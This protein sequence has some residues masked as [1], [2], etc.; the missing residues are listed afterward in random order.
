MTASPLIS[1]SAHKLSGGGDD[2]PFGLSTMS[3]DNSVGKALRWRSGGRFPVIFC[4]VAYFLGKQTKLLKFL[5]KR[6]VKQDRGRDEC[7]ALIKFLCHLSATA[8]YGRAV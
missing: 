7:F 3:V 8:A 4:C 5:S 1:L 2:L 6:K